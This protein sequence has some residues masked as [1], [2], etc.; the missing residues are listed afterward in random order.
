[1]FEISPLDAPTI[2]GAVAVLIA[3]SML[4][5]WQPVRRASRIDPVVVMREN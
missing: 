4:A 3:V 2:M 5:G 1:L